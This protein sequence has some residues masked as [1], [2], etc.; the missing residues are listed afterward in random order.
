MLFGVVYAPREP[1]G[2]AQT[3]LE[4]FTSWQPPLEFIGHWRFAAGGGMGL[5]EAR[6][7]GDLSRRIAP[8]APFFDFTVAQLEAGQEA[9]AP[10]EPVASPAP[11]EVLSIA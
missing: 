3:G 10:E 8:F 6:T 1:A 11:P 5:V 7:A 2:P 4:L 9:P